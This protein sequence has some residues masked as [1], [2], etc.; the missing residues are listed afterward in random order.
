MAHQL[1]LGV[2]DHDG[3]HRDGS[4]PS[5][6]PGKRHLLKAEDIAE[7]LD[8]RVDYVYALTRRDAIPHLRFGWT[9]RFRPEAIEAW[10][11][12]LEAP[13]GHAYPSRSR[14]AAGK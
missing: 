4:V 9:L 13:G 6:A 8:M 1:R 2:G 10:L 3:G 11:E 12:E 5:T 14:G 7:M